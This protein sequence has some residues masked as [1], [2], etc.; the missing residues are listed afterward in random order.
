MRIAILG[1][2]YE[3]KEF[4]PDAFLASREE[5]LGVELADGKVKLVYG[6]QEFFPELILFR[7]PYTEELR[8][9]V[10][11]F[12]QANV[13]VINKPQSIIDCFDELNMLESLEKGGVRTPKTYSLKDYKLPV[14]LK[15]Q[16][17]HRGQGKFLAKTEEELKAAMGKASPQGEF[18]FQEFLEGKNEYRALVVGGRLVGTAKR[19]SENWKKNV[20]AVGE[21]VPIDIPE[22]EEIALKSCR[23]LD[24]EIGGVD[25]IETENGFYV[26][27]VNSEPDFRFFGEAGFKAVKKY[28]ENL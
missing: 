11:K 4:F 22:I 7:C 25:I 21:I 2:E 19:I 27:E 16:G 13:R 8:A 3:W 5:E 26:I 24:L 6:E 18:Y 15:V 14:V 17:L 20:G 12:N 9:M 1:N 23:A 10:E 28:V